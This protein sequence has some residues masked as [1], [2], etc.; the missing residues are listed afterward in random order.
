MTSLPCWW[1]GLLWA[2][3]SWLQLWTHGRQLRCLKRIELWSHSLRWV[4]E[5]LG[6]QIKWKEHSSEGTNMYITDR[7]SAECGGG[8]VECARL[9]QAWWWTTWSQLTNTAVETHI[10][11][12]EP[13]AFLPWQGTHIP[14]SAVLWGELGVPPRTS[15]FYPSCLQASWHRAL[16]S[17]PLNCKNTLSFTVFSLLEDIAVCLL[18]KGMDS[19]QCFH[20]KTCQCFR[21]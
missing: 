9:G 8:G 5:I 7:V 14:T 6:T 18:R 1:S 15:S 2:A 12:Q 10:H 21:G 16:L 13:K 20:H 4:G 3:T 11:E 19:Q 17:C